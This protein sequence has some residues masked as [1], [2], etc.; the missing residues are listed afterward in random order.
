MTDVRRPELLRTETNLVEAGGVAFAESI[1]VDGGANCASLPGR[2]RGLSQRPP[3]AALR[4]DRVRTCTTALRRER[5]NRFETSAQTRTARESA[6]SSGQTVT[7]LGPTSLENGAAALGA[8]AG[9]EAVLLGA[10]QV[11]R[12]KGALQRKPPRK[13][14][15]RCCGKS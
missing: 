11:V 9:A 13:A 4:G 15:P 12:L 8:H 2:R 5:A 7:A 3:G 1:E 10:L 14:T 6:R